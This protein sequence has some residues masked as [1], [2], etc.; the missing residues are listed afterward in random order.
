[1]SPFTSPVMSSVTYLVRNLA[2]RKAKGTGLYPAKELAGKEKI[3][4]PHGQQSMELTIF[5]QPGI[6]DK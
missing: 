3:V 4:S 1:M 6:R 5:G 2:E